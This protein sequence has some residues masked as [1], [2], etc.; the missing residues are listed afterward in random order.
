MLS[1]LFNGLTLVTTP[2]SLLS[3]LVSIALYIYKRYLLHEM[4]EIQT[5]P[6]GLRANIVRVF[7]E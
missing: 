3:L 2:L 5:A 1:I 6:A 4:Q 7:F